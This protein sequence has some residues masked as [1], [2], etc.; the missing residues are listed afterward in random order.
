[1][2]I[3]PDGHFEFKLRRSEMHVAPSELRKS[4]DHGSYKHR[5]PNGAEGLRPPRV[6]RLTE[7]VELAIA[8]EPT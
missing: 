6:F 8:Y 7:A 3:V 5:A 2:F 1:M 4:K